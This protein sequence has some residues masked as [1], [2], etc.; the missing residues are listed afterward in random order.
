MFQVAAAMTEKKPEYSKYGSVKA[1]VEVLRVVKAAASLDNKTVQEWVSDALN[2][3][4]AKAVGR[5]PIK[6]KPPQPKEK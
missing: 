6:R 1:D 4:S 5:K 3:A 2:D